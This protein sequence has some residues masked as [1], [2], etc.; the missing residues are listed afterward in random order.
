MFL[1]AADRADQSTPKGTVFLF[2]DVYAREI[3]SK[4]NKSASQIRNI[5][6]FAKNVLKI[7]KPKT[8][9]NRV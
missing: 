2:S 1:S 6:N 3:N 9:G 5:I 4:W 7:L 8:S